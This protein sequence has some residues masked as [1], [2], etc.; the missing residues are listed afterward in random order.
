MM[1]VRVRITRGGLIAG[2]PARPGDTFEGSAQQALDLA[3]GGRI[4]PL[5]PETHRAA[6][7]EVNGQTAVLMRA[8]ERRQGWVVTPRAVAGGRWH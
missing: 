3:S 4:A 7:D 8:S 5:D 6:L 2:R 1:T